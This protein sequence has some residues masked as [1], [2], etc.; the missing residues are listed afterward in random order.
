MNQQHQNGGGVLAPGRRGFINQQERNWD[1][2]RTSQEFQGSSNNNIQQF[3]DSSRTSYG[4]MNSNKNYWNRQQPG[5][6]GPSVKVS[7]PYDNQ[8]QLRVPI[9]KGA[10]GSQSLSSFGNQRN[11]PQGNQISPVGMQINDFRNS[12]TEVQRRV[13][14]SPHQE[15]PR[16]PLTRGRPSPQN[17]AGPIQQQRQQMEMQ[18]QKS[19][20]QSSYSE[21]ARRRNNQ[22]QRP[23]PQQMVSISEDSVQKIIRKSSSPKGENPK[24]KPEPVREPPKRQRNQQQQTAFNSNQIQKKT[25]VRNNN[26]NK[27]PPQASLAIQ[28]IPGNTGQNDGRL[29]QQGSNSKSQKVPQSLNEDKGGRVEIER[30]TQEDLRVSLSEKDVIV[31]PQALVQPQVSHVVAPDIPSVKIPYRNNNN[32]NIGQP[33]RWAPTNWDNK[34]QNM[35]RGPQEQP[36]FIM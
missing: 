7:I 22:P 10:G 18:Q 4:A 26:N 21:D 34:R 1:R 9:R 13:P 24:M 31:G 19:M 33:N 35:R 2:T 29:R 6:E 20:Q 11:S 8:E 25:S 14:P 17:F 3:A 16:V 27:I 5:Q 12:I 23:P 36:P 28:R 32:N 15:L 30:D